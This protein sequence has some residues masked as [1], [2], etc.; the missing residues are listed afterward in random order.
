MP[1]PISTTSA[2]AVPMPSA[3]PRIVSN[4]SAGAGPV[5]R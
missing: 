1:S 5:S 2:S 4:V 3:T